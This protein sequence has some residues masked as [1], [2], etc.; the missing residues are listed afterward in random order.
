MITVIV[1]IMFVVVVW[2]SNHLSDKRVKKT[3]DSLD[4]KLK[5]FNNERDRITER[6]AKARKEFI[7][8]TDDMMER[9]KR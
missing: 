6:E 3:L 5:E 4:Q 7:A 2:Y 1:T 9:I 8:Y